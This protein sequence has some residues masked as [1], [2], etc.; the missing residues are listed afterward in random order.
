MVKFARKK[1]LSAG[2]LLHIYIGFGMLS[3]LRDPGAPGIERLSG[4]ERK[5]NISGTRD[6]LTRIRRLV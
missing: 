4:G 1:I 3:V 5:R 6:N 2:G